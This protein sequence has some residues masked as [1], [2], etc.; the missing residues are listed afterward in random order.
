GRQGLE[1]PAV[2]RPNPCLVSSLPSP[3]S[4]VACGYN[5]NVFLLVDG[6]VF[7]FGMAASNGRVAGLDTVR[8]VSVAAGSGTSFAVTEAGELFSWGQGRFGALGTGSEA[9]RALPTRLDCF[10]EKRRSAVAHVSAGRHHS[11]AITRSRRTY[12]WGDD[13]FGQ[14]GIGRAQ[15]GNGGRHQN[16]PV[17]IS[18]PAVMTPSQTSA[19]GRHTLCLVEVAGAPPGRETAVFSWGARGH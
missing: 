1:L 6:S 8:V 9:D 17:E 13:R 18:W 7:A 10:G 14:L 5:H 4:A 15:T 19:G 2:A 16:R 3:V 11:I 12:V